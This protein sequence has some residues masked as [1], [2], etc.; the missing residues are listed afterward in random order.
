VGTRKIVGIGLLALQAGAVVHAR[1]SS[2]RYFCW[3]PHDSQTEYR[4][5]AMAS[6]EPLDDATLGRRYR[7]PPTGVEAYSSQHVLDIVRQYEETYGRDD[8]VRV[9]VR[10]R[11]NGGAPQEWRWPVR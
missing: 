10:Y 6:G 8:E 1:F 5:E 9:V 11:V 3:A 4:I 2:A 7:F